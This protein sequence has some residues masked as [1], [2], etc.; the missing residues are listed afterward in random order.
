MIDVLRPRRRRRELLAAIVQ[1]GY[2]LATS[3]INIGE[4]YAGLR[5]NEI[6]PAERFLNELECYP[7]TAAIARRAGELKRDR[8]K[9]G[10]T[11][12][13]PDV[14]VAATAMEYE[15]TL[16]TDNRKDFPF[17]ELALFPL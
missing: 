16:M 13:L 11:L 1:S 2:I 10:R 3:A 15:L 9:K 4:L 17:P 5:A 12:S 7:L 14:I 8:A 6:E